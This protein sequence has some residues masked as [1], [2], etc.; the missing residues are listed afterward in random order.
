M[1]MR[2]DEARR[3]GATP[4][5]PVPLAAVSPHFLNA[6]VVA[7]DHRFWTHGGI[8]FV[9]IRSALGYRRNGFSW[10]SPRDIA[11]LIRSFPRAWERRDALRG[12]STITQQL[13]KNLYL[14]PSRNP[15]RKLKEAVTAYRLEAVLGKRR[16]L[17]L[18]VNVAELG[19]GVW[20]VDAGSWRYFDRPARALSRQQAAALAATLPFPLA[21]NPDFRPGRM[22]W[23]QALIL[24]RM[25]GERVIVPVA[26]TEPARLE[27]PALDSLL[28]SLR[29]PV[30]TLPPE[31]PELAP[32]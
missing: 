29:A 28:D 3:G 32:E 5:H 15:L 6:V 25:R 17:E 20:G 24:R 8:D 2:G 9:E 31:P 19:P 23:R 30:E 10:T 7:E 4:Y 1:H 12:A 18:Y 22:R 14:S 27:P 16:I 13:A 26:T 11:E 21:S